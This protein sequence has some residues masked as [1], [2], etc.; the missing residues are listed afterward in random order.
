MFGIVIGFTSLIPFGGT[1]AIIGVTGL[2]A[3]QDIWLGLKVLIVAFVLGQINENVVA[4][5]LIGSV[6][7]VDNDRSPAP[8]NSDLQKL[9]MPH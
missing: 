7:R 5:R 4:P 8:Y 2:L 6:S 3:F 1:G 9:A